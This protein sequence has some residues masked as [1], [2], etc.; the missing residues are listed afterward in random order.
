MVT[1]TPPGLIAPG[2]HC[3]AASSSAASSFTQ[4]RSAWNAWA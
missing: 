1:T 2:S 3:S 4:M